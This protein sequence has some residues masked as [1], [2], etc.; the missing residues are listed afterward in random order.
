MRVGTGDQSDPLLE[1][2]T[3]SPSANPAPRTVTSEPSGPLTGHTV[4]APV[5]PLCDA[6]WPTASLGLGAL[7]GAWH[8]IMAAIQHNSKEAVLPLLL[9][10]QSAHFPL[11]R[12]RC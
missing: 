3:V 12:H 2:T 7:A 10:S 5:P 8:E 11:P 6:A 9:S 1:T 4:E